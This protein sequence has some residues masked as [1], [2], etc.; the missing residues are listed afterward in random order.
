MFIRIFETIIS[1]LKTSTYFI[2]YE[3]FYPINHSYIQYSYVYKVERK[4]SWFNVSIINKSSDFGRDYDGYI[5]K[6]VK[7]QVFLVIM[8]ANF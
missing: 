7:V 5:F 2:F 4:S 3:S 8:I 1:A 6:N